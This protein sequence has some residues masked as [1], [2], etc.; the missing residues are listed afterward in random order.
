M[1]KW[2]TSKSKC[3]LKDIKKTKWQDTEEENIIV[4]NH[5]S[6][7]RLVSEYIKNLNALIIRQ[8]KF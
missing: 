8:K 2:V 7:K 3:F 5:L 6:D 1:I 4:S